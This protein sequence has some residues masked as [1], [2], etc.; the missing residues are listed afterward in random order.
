[1]LFTLVPLVELALLIWISQYT[2]LLFTISLVILTGV[3]GAWLAREQGLRCWL[4]VQR[5]L[6]AG[7]L[8]AEPLL[9]GL[10]IL[11]AGAVLITPGVLTDAVGFALLVP[12]LR[13]MVR[14]Y[15][16]ERFKTRITVEPMSGFRGAPTDENDVIDVEYHS[17]D[18][19]PQ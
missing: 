18:D 7:Q 2:G 12:P 1:L 15:L 5:Q 19:G 17:S 11:V 8:P 9:D 16:A 3:V 10:M 13:A 4:E 14:R 6:N